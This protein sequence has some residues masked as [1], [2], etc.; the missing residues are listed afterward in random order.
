MGVT[1]FV[2]TIYLNININGNNLNVAVNSI[3]P[4]PEGPTTLTGSAPIL[5]NPT[6]T[7]QVIL[8]HTA[9]EILTTSNSIQIL[10]L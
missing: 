9:N 7:L 6:Q 10:I 2:F 1:F 4:S 8:I 3:E 5:L